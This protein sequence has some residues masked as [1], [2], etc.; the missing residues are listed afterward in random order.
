[1][2]QFKM[3]VVVG[4][5]ADYETEVHRPAFQLYIYDYHWGKTKL[6]LL[7]N[8][9]H[10]VYIFRIVILMKHVLFHIYQSDGMMLLLIG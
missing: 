9:F 1:M 4:K 2:K 7:L 6:Y 3:A 8:Y 10:Y 5:Y